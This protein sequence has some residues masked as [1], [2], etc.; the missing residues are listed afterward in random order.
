MP[1]NWNAA[2]QVNTFYME[3]RCPICQKI[4]NPPTQENKEAKVFPFCSNRCKLI[5]LGAWLDS[6]YRVAVQEQPTKNT[7][8]PDESINEQ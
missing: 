7:A 1:K 4:V 6:R 5:D 2:L 8:S 3:I